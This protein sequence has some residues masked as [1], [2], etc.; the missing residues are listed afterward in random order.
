MKTIGQYLQE[1]RKYRKMTL[2]QLSQET[3]IRGEFLAAIEEEHW[4]KL[5][6][7]SVVVGFVKS[8]AGALGM[9]Q[10]PVIAILRRDYPPKKTIITY[11]KAEIP[12]E[13]RWSPKLTFLLGAG[14]ILAVIAGYLII[15]YL[16]FVRPPNLA[17]D[18]PSEAQEIF[19]NQ[20]V[21]SGS[22]DP[23]TTV[24]VNTQPALVGTDGSFATTIEITNNVTTVEVV[25]TSRAGKETR[26]TRTIKPE[27]EN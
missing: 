25:A 17:V 15:Q 9:E 26:I 19:E 14:A 24:V 22:T 23:D 2:P 8:I 10:E 4:G 7:Y 18:M 5:P 11:P 3:K 13:F 27:L 20:L 21:V 1:A 16:T 12:R 6:E